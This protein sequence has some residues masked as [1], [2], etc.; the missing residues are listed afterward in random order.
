MVMRPRQEAQAVMFY[1]VS[2]CD[3]V[4]QSRVFRGMDRFVELRASKEHPA[5]MKVR[6][7]GRYLVWS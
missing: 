6:Q 4:P 7:A 1:A 2:I 3:H 5:S